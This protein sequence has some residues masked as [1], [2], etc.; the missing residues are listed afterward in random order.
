MLADEKGFLFFRELTPEG[1]DT[2]VEGIVPVGWD[3]D[4][5]SWL[6]AALA[7]RVDFEDGGVEIKQGFVV[8]NVVGVKLII[9]FGRL[10]GSA[11]FVGR[12][13]VRRE[14]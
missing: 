12:G 8:N 13:R 1:F 11:E 3:P 9:N 4:R 2:V 7:G 6:P 5:R 14:L 10:D